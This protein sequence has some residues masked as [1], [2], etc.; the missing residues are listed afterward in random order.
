[1]YITVIFHVEYN[2]INRPMP[3]FLQ[4]LARARRLKFPWCPIFSTAPVL[5][6]ANLILFAWQVFDD[7][8]SYSATRK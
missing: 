6:L 7:D 4:K 1:M 3:V 2:K 5:V 8:K